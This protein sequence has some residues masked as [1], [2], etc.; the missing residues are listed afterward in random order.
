MG[1]IL[2]AGAA[3]QPRRELR[4]ALERDG[5]V[6]GET[7]TATDAIELAHY[8]SQDV[9][10][11]DSHLSSTDPCALSRTI[12]SASDIGI[13]MLIP[14]AAE[15]TRIDALNAGADDYLSPGF[16]VAELLARVRAIL[17]RIRS[18]PGRHDHIALQDRAIDLRSH[19]VQGPGNQ[20]THLTPRE[21]E[22]LK[23]LVARADKPVNHRE[24]AQTVWNRDGSGDLEYVRIVISQ[25][26]RKLE[27]DYNA[28]KYIL[29]ERSI[30]YRFNARPVAQA[31]ARETQASA[32]S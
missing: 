5:H 15:Q 4:A 26:R 20:V 16:V 24:L 21:I 25:L 13:I 17:R 14:D 10:I 30:G 6:V 18:S 12:R 32:G 9:L 22:V 1:R 31:S 7:T 2:V 23:Y 27:P 3:L 28:P 11:L 29:T 19:K 8:G